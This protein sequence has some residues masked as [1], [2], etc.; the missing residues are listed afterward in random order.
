MD[1]RR[2]RKALIVCLAFAGALGASTASEAAVCTVTDRADLNVAGTLRWCVGQVNAGA[3]DEIDIAQTGNYQLETALQIDRD[4]DVEAT[5]V[6]VLVQPGETFNDDTLIRVGCGTLACAPVVRIA[7]VEVWSGLAPGWRG[8]DVRGG[9]VLTL[10]RVLI[11]DFDTTLDGG[12]LRAQGET[13]V[14][15]VDSELLGNR[16]ARGGAVFSSGTLLEVT[17]SLF[18]DNR[19]SSGGGAIHF[20]MSPFILAGSLEVDNSDFVGNRATTSGG[21]IQVTGLANLISASV[22]ASRFTGNQGPS[23]GAIDGFADI[24]SSIFSANRANVGGAL[25]LA[26]ASHVVDSLLTSNVAIQ[27]GGIAFRTTSS[28]IGLTL[29]G[30]T[31]GKNDF[32]RQNGAIGAGI[33]LSGGKHLIENTTLSANGAPGTVMLVSTFGGGLA[34]VGGA[35]L[36]LEHATLTANAGDTGAGVHVDSASQIAV[37][38]SIVAHSQIGPDCTFL[39]AFSQTT[40]LS[41]DASCS[42]TYRASPQL[43]PL[44]S[45]GGPTPTHMPA[46]GSL[47]IDRGTCFSAVDQRGQSRPGVPGTPCDIGSVEAR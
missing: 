32:V 4:V 8:I 20:G 24:A 35:S 3:Y 17:G 25:S 46:P 39:A 1:P 13:L 37:R 34:L 29:R 36:E 44:A 19:A 15:L 38:S 30:S 14:H 31:L 2:S 27:G 23:G 22:T 7:R 11:A 40:S 28:Q 12:A 16:G 6:G 21:A 18:D 9:S 41:T 10:D 42:F 47:A 43:G 5:V 26:G 33:Y 45:N